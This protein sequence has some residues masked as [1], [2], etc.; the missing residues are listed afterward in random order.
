[1]S[2]SIIVSSPR[3]SATSN[4]PSPGPSATPH[5]DHFEAKKP[6][7]FSG[8]DSM[9]QSTVHLLTNANRAESRRLLATTGDTH[10]T[11]EDADDVRRARP[12]SL[13]CRHAHRDR[14]QLARAL[15][16]TVARRSPRSLVA[17]KSQ[18]SRI[19]FRPALR[20][21]SR[22]ERQRIQ[23]TQVIDLSRRHRENPQEAREKQ[24]IY[25]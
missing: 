20:H 23:A 19:F 15:V 4:A 16:V 12:R 22:R 17:R 2:P 11:T 18:L 8:F 6:R 3:L 5:P 10:G 24:A 9:V 21:R 25:R 13:S 1:M 7:K 14:A